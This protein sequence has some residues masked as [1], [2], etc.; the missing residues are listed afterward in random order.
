M[1]GLIRIRH[2]KASTRA[3]LIRALIDFV[4]QSRVDFTRFANVDEMTDHLTRLFM[5]LPNCRDSWPAFLEPSLFHMESLVPNELKESNE[6][7]H[8]PEQC[9]T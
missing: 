7:V 6:E 3:G 4:A 2:H 1:S 9:M 5:R 8:E